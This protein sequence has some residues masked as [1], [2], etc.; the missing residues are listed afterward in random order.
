MTDK[1]MDRMLPIASAISNNKF[2]VSLR[3]GFMAAFP[4]TMFASIAMIIQNLP[5]T[6]GFDGLLPKEIIT[7]LNDF[8]GP[9]GNATMSVSTVFITFGIAYHL[10]GKLKCNKLYTGSVAL[11]SFFMLLPFTSNDSGTF[12][13]LSK[14]GSQGMFVGI[15]T[16]MVATEIFAFFENRKITI[17]MPEQVPPAIAQ[18][19]IA[20]IP[21]AATL[22]VFNVIR[23]GFTFTAW[24]NVFDCLFTLLQ[25][26][27]VNLGSSLPATLLAVIMAQLLWWFGVHGQAVV[28]T[29]MDPIWNTLALENYAAFS[30]G[31]PVPHIICSTFMGVFPLIGGNGMTLGIIL[32]SLFIARS[33]RLKKTMKMVVAPSFFNISEPITFGLPIVL[34]PIVLIPWVLAPVVTVIISYCAISFGFVPKP[35]GVTVVWTTPMFLSGWIGTGSI[36]GGI[37]QLVNVV[38]SILIWLPFMKG[39]DRTYL[40]DEKKVDMDCNEVL[41]DSNV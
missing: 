32:V 2:L 18:S 40:N 14:L 20:I 12:M 10:G 8:L 22:L 3:D 30:A 16:A 15:I 7:F 36:T 37:L 1:I 39:L 35:I 38:I 28:N 17:K 21:G 19:F 9:V 6:F 33:V 26:P 31:T 4:A 5:V 25:Q 13:P 34:N 41:G 27:L 24:G 29:V 23:Y 11:A